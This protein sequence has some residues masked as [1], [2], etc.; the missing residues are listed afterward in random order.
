MQVN[1]DEM[2][3]TRKEEREERREGTCN[4]SG[5][6]DEPKRGFIKE[7]NIKI[8]GGYLNC[9]DKANVL[10]VK[11]TVINCPE[12]INISSRLI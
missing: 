8:L 4:E 12:N 10:S 9:K 3:S 1:N 2:T 6:R 11:A 7:S 5:F